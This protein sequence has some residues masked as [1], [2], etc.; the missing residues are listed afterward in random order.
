MGGSTY[1][2]NVRA[3]ARE[4]LSDF[5]RR[6]GPV[7]VCDVSS[8]VM[9]L[10]KEL[11]ELTCGCHF[12]RF[13]GTRIGRARK[14]Y[15]ER[16][17]AG[18]HL[19]S[20]LG[21]FATGSDG[22]L[23]VLTLDDG[24]V[25]VVISPFVARTNPVM[26]LMDG[27]VSITGRECVRDNILKPGISSN[28]IVRAAEAAI[29]SRSN[30]RF[31]EPVAGGTTVNINSLHSNDFFVVHLK[32]ACEKWKESIETSGGD[33]GDR[34]LSSEHRRRRRSVDHGAT[35]DVESSSRR[36][37]GHRRR[38]NYNGEERRNY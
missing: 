30:M 31:L 10:T 28:P 27:V 26:T 5:E 19:Y 33:Q 29:E 15:E 18:K 32:S 20:L 37:H 23:T 13:I 25:V 12:G 6:Y 21:A 16:V 7:E 9:G 4:T 3:V 2:P 8:Y 34:A 11:P 38:R 22:P 24:T 17:K 1:V 14:E 35:T 36:H